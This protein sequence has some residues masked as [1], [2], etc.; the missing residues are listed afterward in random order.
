M[1]DE[2]RQG[3]DFSVTHIKMTRS[4]SAYTMR[5]TTVLNLSM[6]RYDVRFRALGLHTRSPTYSFMVWHPVT[7]VVHFTWYYSALFECFDTFTDRSLLAIL[8]P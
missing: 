5:V 1:E 4:H 7:S 3:L 6:L 2:Y 8:F